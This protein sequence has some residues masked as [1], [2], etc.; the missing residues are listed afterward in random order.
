MKASD[1]RK[2][3]KDECLK[4][5]KNIRKKL[6]EIRFTSASSKVKNTKEGANLRKDVARIL[7]ILKEK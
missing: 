7:T 5:I 4:D 3:T 6:R 1:I 2:K